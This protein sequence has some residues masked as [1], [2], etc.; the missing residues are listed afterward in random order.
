MSRAM[1]EPPVVTLAASCEDIP[2]DYFFYKAKMVF[3]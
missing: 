2:C 1:N 3:Q